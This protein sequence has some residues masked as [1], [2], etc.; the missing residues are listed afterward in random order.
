VHVAL[1]H[2]E[3]F[4]GESSQNYY[5]SDGGPGLQMYAGDVVILASSSVV[6]GTEGWGFPHPTEPPCNWDGAPGPGI[7]FLSAGL[8][9]HSASTITGAMGFDPYCNGITAAPIEGTGTLAPVAPD[10]PTLEMIGTPTPG[11]MVQVVVH[12]PPGSSASLVLGR[13]PVLVADGLT[14]IEQLAGT[15]RQVNL[16][17]VSGS[18]QIAVGWNLPGAWTVGS[19]AV[20]LA[21]V[22]VPGGALR[23]TNSVPVVAR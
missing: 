5:G 23:R 19:F 8:V 21:R 20:L 10:D 3:G 1:S 11:G 16:G 17:I 4:P 13:N 12:A 15:T 22:T 2:I 14:E 6:G 7:R 18:G 9:E